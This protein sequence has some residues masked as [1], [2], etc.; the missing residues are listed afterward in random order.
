ME[1]QPLQTGRESKT[2]AVV[3]EGHGQTPAGARPGASDDPARA[4]LDQAR[5]HHR[6]GR[7]AEAQALYR[8]VLD[9]QP[10]NVEA[11]YALAVLA[12]QAG[13]LDVTIQHLKQA[14]SHRPD[15]VAAHIYL[16]NSHLA[17]NQRQEAVRHYRKAVELEPNHAGAHLNLAR[18]FQ[19]AGRFEQAVAHFESA[20]ALDPELAEAHSSLRRLLRGRGRAEAVSKRR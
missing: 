12:Q 17:M 4:P 6:A 1:S 14:V 8:K 15:F 19:R 16:G 10:G 20:L 18:L 11:L 2:G 13:R 3:A 9:V 7:L 5:A